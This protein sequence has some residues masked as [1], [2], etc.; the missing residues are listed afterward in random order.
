MP[1]AS[2]GAGISIIL[3]CPVESIQQTLCLTLVLYN[4]VGSFG[5]LGRV[6]NR[7]ERLLLV[8]EMLLYL[9]NGLDTFVQLITGHGAE[10]GI[11]HV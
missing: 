4:T 6:L 1:D 2:D 7:R 9:L 8:P 10:R 5:T 11:R 3:A